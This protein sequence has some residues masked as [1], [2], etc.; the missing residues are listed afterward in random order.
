MTTDNTSR[1]TPERM[2]LPFV[3]LA[4]FCSPTGMPRLG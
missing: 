2:D 1:N 4:T 3:G